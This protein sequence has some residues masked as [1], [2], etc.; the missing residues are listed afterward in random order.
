MDI[1]TT[2][3]IAKPSADVNGQEKVRQQKNSAGSASAVERKQP[4]AGR[5]AITVV[6]GG[7]TNERRQGK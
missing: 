1:K 6:K 3:R 2:A 5:P 4:G 7:K